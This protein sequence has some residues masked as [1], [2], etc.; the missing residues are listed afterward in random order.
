MATTIPALDLSTFLE[1]PR[2]TIDTKPYELYHH[3][4][5]SVTDGR[6]LRALWERM[7]TIEQ[8]LMTADVSSEDPDVQKAIKADEAEYLAS[9]QAYV[10]SIVVNLPKSVA[11]K[12]LSANALAIITHFLQLPQKAP[13]AEATK[14]V[15]ARKNRTGSKSALN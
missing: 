14:A 7:G 1:R 13:T 5:L 10:S 2:L 12:I 15:K 6:R 9:A 11:A 8:R 3:L 4:E